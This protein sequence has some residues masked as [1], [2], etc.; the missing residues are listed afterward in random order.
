[1]FQDNTVGAFNSTASHFQSVISHAHPPRRSHVL[2]V[3]SVLPDPAAVPR[4]RQVE[5]RGS[6]PR[7]AAADGIGNFETLVPRTT[8]RG[9]QVE[10]IA[11]LALRRRAAGSQELSTADGLFETPSVR[12]PVLRAGMVRCS[13]DPHYRLLGL[14]RTVPPCDRSM[15]WVWPR[16]F[17]RLLLQV[18]GGLAC[19]SG[20]ARGG[21]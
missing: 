4:S 17:E 13:R 9:N 20:V 21:E 15:R 3:T 6:V 19:A 7:S 14:P 16:S 8:A 18:V 11:S 10:H 12:L 5:P 1:V 2:T